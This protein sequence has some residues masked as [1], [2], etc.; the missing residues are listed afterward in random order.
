MDKALKIG[1]PAALA[2]LGVKV[3]G[4]LASGSK[5]AWVQAA[6]GVGGAAVGLVVAGM[7]GGGKSP[8]A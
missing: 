5:S 8:I 2:Y 4:G 1:I 3:V 6:A 7:I